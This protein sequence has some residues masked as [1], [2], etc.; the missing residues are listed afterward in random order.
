VHSI[1]ISRICAPT[2]PFSSLE[3][4]GAQDLSGGAAALDFGLH[5]GAWSLAF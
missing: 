1:G 4:G 5:I 2:R 3:V